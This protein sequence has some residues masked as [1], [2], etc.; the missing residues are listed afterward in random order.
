LAA[1]VA[2]NKL[3][4]YEVP[5]SY[6]GRTYED[7]KKISWRDGFAALWFILKYRFTSNYA[8]AGKVAL[9]ASRAGSQ[10]QSLD[11]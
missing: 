7:G 5:V 1:K 3:R 6:N 8:D 11:V 2:R 10:V 9:D 4:I